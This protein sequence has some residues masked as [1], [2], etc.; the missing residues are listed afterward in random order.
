MKENIKILEDFLFKWNNGFR[1]ISF[2]AIKE[3]IT[4]VNNLMQAYKDLKQ[5]NE[6][7]RLFIWNSPNMNPEHAIAYSNL[8]RDAYIEGKAEEQERARKFIREDCIERQK[9]KNKIKELEENGYWNFLE[10]RDLEITINILKKL[11]EV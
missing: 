1:P 6:S 8:R 5:E 4:P 3:I 7:L 9:I 10:S 11:L 2:D